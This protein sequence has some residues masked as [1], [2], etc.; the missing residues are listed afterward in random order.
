[1]T[2]EEKRKLRYKCKSDKFLAKYGVS[3]DEVNERLNRDKLKHENVILDAN[4]QFKKKNKN[5]FNK[6]M[7]SYYKRHFWGLFGVI[8]LTLIQIAGTFITMPLTQYVVDYV[9]VS[10]WTE[11]IELVI[12]II[13]IYFALCGIGFFKDFGLRKISIKVVEQ[14]R[15]DLA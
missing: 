8:L 3:L 9:T 10:A 12:C 1:M 2:K 13:V 5:Q 15:Q 6:L 11:A 14:V 4:N 7:W